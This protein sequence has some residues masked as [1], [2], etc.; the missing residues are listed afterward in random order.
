MQTPS[1]ERFEISIT[2]AAGHVSAA[3]DAPLAF[4]PLTSLVPL[5]RSLGEE[6]QRLEEARAA[7]GGRLR[8]CTK[9]CAACCRM[10]V[11]L[12]P[13]EAFRLMDH[14]RRWPVEQQEH[15]A[16][17]LEATKSALVA[18]GIWQRLLDVAESEQPPNDEELAPLNEAYYSLRIPCPF[19][20]ENTCSV[21][22]ERPSAC[23]ELLV[24]SPP[25]NCNDMVSGTVEALPIPLRVGTILGLVWGELTA[26]VPRMIPLPLVADWVERHQSEQAQKWQ[27]T[28]LL[29]SALDKVRRYLNQVA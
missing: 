20:E 4:I 5:L 10:L 23:R 7:A 21:Y 24:T 18:H 11:P 9:G 15:L 14:V 3:V 16:V 27:G 1:T 12:S 6:A 17:R 19:L 28:V 25:V 22:E 26:S 29:T 13:P 2:T 8:S